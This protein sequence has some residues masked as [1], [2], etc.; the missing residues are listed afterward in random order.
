MQFIDLINPRKKIKDA[1]PIN[2][3]SSLTM[4][5]VFVLRIL[6][7]LVIII[8][9]NHAPL[10]YCYLL[11]FFTDLVHFWTIGKINH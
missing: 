10:I 11:N 1:S 8:S 5:H 4:L 3:H 2:Y 7:C 9:V 6:K